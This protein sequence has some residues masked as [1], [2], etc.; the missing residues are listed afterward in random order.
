MANVVGRNSGEYFS[1]FPWSNSVPLT[2]ILLTS[3]RAPV[4]SKEWSDE[5]GMYFAYQVLV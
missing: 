3:Y 4:L 2:T 1:Y 5:M